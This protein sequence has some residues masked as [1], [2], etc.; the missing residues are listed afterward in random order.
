MNPDDEGDGTDPWT[1]PGHHDSSYTIWFDEFLKERATAHGTI[2]R[3]NP[4]MPDPV[5]YVILVDDN[6]DLVDDVDSVV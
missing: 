4:D 1:D 6:V 3:N 5:P 2:A